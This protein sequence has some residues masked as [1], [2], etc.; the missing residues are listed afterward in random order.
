MEELRDLAKI[1]KQHSQ[2]S[3]QLVNQSF[4]KNEKPKDSILY[5]LIVNEKVFTDEEASRL[6]LNSNSS[7]RN[8]RNTKSKLRQKLLNHLFFLDYEKNG[9]THYHQVLYDSILKLSQFKILITLGKSWI[10]IKRIPL[11]IKT[12]IDYDLIEMALEGL[13]ILRNEYSKLGKFSLETEFENEILKIMPLHKTIIECEALYY[14][15]LA[16]I[17][18]SYNSCEKILD[19][20][21][22]R[23]Q[24]IEKQALK[25]NNRRLDIISGMLDI[26]YSRINHKY[27]KILE[28]CN[29]LEKKYIPGDKNKISVGID[30][31]LIASL[32]LDA[33]YR[34]NDYSVFESYCKQKHT[35]FEEGSTEW[36]SFM[37][38]WFLLLMKS[39]KYN[40][41]AEIFKSVKSNHDYNKTGWSI[42]ERW[43]IYRAYLCFMTDCKSVQWGFNMD[44]FNE[45]NQEFP[46]QNNGYNIAILIAGLMFNLRDGD[47][48]N[49]KQSINNLHEFSSPHLDKRHNYRNSIFIRMLEIMVEKNFD[50]KEISDKIRVYQQKLEENYVTADLSEEFEVIPYEKLWNHIFEI[51]KS[52]KHYLHYHFY[53]YHET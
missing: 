41:A 19:T 49:V 33:I 38:Y 42:R 13:L 11:F 34:I 27:D 3:L 5:D 25:F 36:F 52:N 10:V 37:E 20:I 43:R 15:T 51:L 8:Y 50:H 32:K 46:K 16:I 40:D 6:L 48:A 30:P 9:Y 47:I 18:K 14:D 44:K 24:L 53:H 21:P 35:L 4:R 17:N 22:E 12:A 26:Y 7:N 2:R 1:V 23:I 45:M 28:S 31:A 39:G 29:Y